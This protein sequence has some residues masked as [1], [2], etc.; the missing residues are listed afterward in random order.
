MRQQAEIIR[1]H[2]RTSRAQMGVSTNTKWPTLDETR[3]VSEEISDKV[4]F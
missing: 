2:N 4:L 3:R 1:K